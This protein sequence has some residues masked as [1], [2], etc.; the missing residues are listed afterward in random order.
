VTDLAGAMAWAETAEV[1]IAVWEKE[2]EMSLRAALKQEKRPAS[3]ALLVGPEGGLEEEEIEQLKQG[4]FIIA[5][6]G[7]R[8]LRTETAAMVGLGLVQYEWG[9]LG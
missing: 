1:K 2:K 5:S 8:I 7:R 9:D 3:A 4:G 6:L